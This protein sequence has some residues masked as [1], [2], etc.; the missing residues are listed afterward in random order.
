M[1][2]H[3]LFCRA[4]NREVRILIAGSPLCEDQA[5]AR[6]EGL[7]CLEVGDECIET[8]CPLGSSAPDAMVGR[9]IRN[10]VPLDSLTTVT[11]ECPSCGNEAEMV[12]YGARRA[13]CTLCGTAARWAY[14]HVEPG[15]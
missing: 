15:D 14:D 3:L 5:P 8:L 7:V 6:D 4:C 9:L 10:G 1:K 12:R 13:A 11:A 2:N